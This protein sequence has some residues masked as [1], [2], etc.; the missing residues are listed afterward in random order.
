MSTSNINIYSLNVNGLGDKEKRFSVINWLNNNHLG[1]T[2][3]QEVH[4]TIA[5]EKG[6]RI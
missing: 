1:V 4:S 3:L 2:L 6:K 5:S